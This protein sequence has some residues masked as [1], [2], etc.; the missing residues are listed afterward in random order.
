M[1]E[2][3]TF[4]NE[5]AA[6]R[7]QAENI[8]RE[9]AALSTGNLETL[10]VEETRR[11][12]HEL[13]VHQIEL[14]L[15]NEEL[16]RALSEINAAR[17]K[18]FDLNDLA[19][20]GYF[21]LSE[22]GLIIEANFTGA[23]LLG[24]VRPALRKQLLTRF[25]CPEDHDVYFYLLR[26]LFETGAPQV[27]EMRMLRRDGSNFWARLEATVAPDSEN[28]ESVC[29]AAISDITDQR[30]MEEE[31]RLHSQIINNISEGISLIKTG[32]ETI[33]YTNRRIEQLFGYGPMELLGKHVSIFNAP[34]DRPFL[35][36]T[37]EII[38][39][40]NDKGY[41]SGEFKNI[42]KNGT[43]FWCHVTV[44]WFD[45]EQY[46][47]VWLSV[48][49]DITERKKAENALVEAHRILKETQA[50]AKIGGWEY[51][52]ITQ[53]MK[54]TEEVYGIRGVEPN[55]DPS[56]LRSNLS[57]YS[58]ESLPVIERAFQRCI[59]VGEAY[60]LELDFIRA[61]GER[62]WVRA[63]GEP[64]WE[65]DKVVRVRGNLMDITA[66]KLAEEALRKSEAR[67]RLL[68]ENMRDVIWTMDTDY[69]LTYVSPS[70]IHLLGYTPEE[71]L[72]KNFA[73]TLPPASLEIVWQAQERRR[74]AEAAGQ[75]RLVNRME[76]E[77][78]HKDGSL[79]W[80]EF[81]SQAI[82]DELGN[83]I[84]YM[85][86]SRDITSRKRAEEALWESEELHRT[87]LRTAKD[88]FWMIDMIG[89]LMEVNEAYCLM[90]G[91]SEQE[92]LAISLA[93]LEV[94]E[95]P[96]DMAAHFQKIRAF[97]TDR[98]ESR[99]RRKDGI[100]IDVEI[101]VQ[102]R[103]WKG[104]RFVAFLRDITARKR[105]EEEKEKLQTQLI[106][107]QKMESVGILAGGIAHEFNNILQTI[108]GYTS[109]ILLGKTETDEEYAHLRAIEKA[110]K[111]AAHLV[112]QLLFFSRGLEAER[113]EVDLNQEVLHARNLLRGAIPKIV[114]IEVFPGRRLWTVKADPMQIEQALLN[115]GNNAVDA[116]PKG[117][118]LIIKTENITLDKGYSR[119]HAGVTPG[120]Y[121]LLTFSDTGCG[122]SKETMEKIF[123]PFFTTKG[124]GKGAGLSLAS[125]YGIVKGHGGY[126]TCHSE[127]GLGT[128]FEILFPAIE[129]ADS[130]KIKH[131][132]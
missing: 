107:A 65:G 79:V 67:Y 31:L 58:P 9:K 92:L 35:E 45:H 120:N 23:N 49:E 112:K 89:R 57:F 130:G 131:L 16:R 90:S 128:T 6:L 28:G 84:G 48:H 118:K 10:S 127:L 17:V 1:T 54:W 121:V 13:Q 108:M 91:Y 38:E 104:G 102:Y 2:K 97:G 25:I 94:I 113:L 114:D 87:I 86:L 95:S 103:S 8:A 117:G 76:I 50:L 14:E 62:I 11:L 22:K 36:T 40:I 101:S 80:V 66:H 82:F 52:V 122:L 61:G 68:V 43:I 46:G 75:T 71:A 5:D 59:S 83:K 88:G 20:V 47:N 81:I 70:V 63:M 39:S 26:Q 64:V 41:W 110:A 56:D 98:F 129:Q 27:S 37:R 12:V 125:V 126:I 7:R 105:A 72:S 116:M 115:L 51:E 15:R 132:E 123:D 119:K 78:Y 21:I 55:Y 4:P 44:T 93:D 100:I 24:M 33:V 85:G 106:H 124:I 111:R 69:R 60:D 34:G 29:R 96:A 19:P 77:H 109:I 99:H 42:K 30:Q 53:Q 73:E 3:V 18:Y 32:D 74:E